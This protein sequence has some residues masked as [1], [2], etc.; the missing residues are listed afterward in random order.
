M[1]LGCRVYGPNENKMSDGGRERAWLR[2]TGCSYHE[3]D[4]GAASRS[5]HRLVRRLV[6]FGC[7]VFHGLRDDYAAKSDSR[8]NLPGFHRIGLEC[9]LILRAIVVPMRN[10]VLSVPLCHPIAEAIQK[11]VKGDLSDVQDDGA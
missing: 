4:I 8:S 9:R 3:L 6:I 10:A 7:S 11:L 5:L 1:L 2:V